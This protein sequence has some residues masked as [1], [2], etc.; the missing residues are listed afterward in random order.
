MRFFKAWKPVATALLFT[1]SAQVAIAHEG[2][3]HGARTTKEAFPPCHAPRRHP[4]RLNLSQSPKAENSRSTLIGLQHNE[5]VL[6]RSVAVETPQGS[7]EAK[8]APDGTYRLPA[9]WS[10][11]PGHYDLIFTVAK[12]NI[13]DVV[14]LTLDIPLATTGAATS[15]AGGFA[16]P[17]MARGLKENLSEN[18]V[19]ILIAL[20]VTFLAGGL[21]GAIWARQRNIA[22]LLLVGAG[23]IC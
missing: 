3:D 19:A 17:A 5:P 6:A 16:T 23:L 15:P 8:A 9:P 12:D 7:V 22:R 2:E 11:A 10:S 1:L 18:H 21:G 14:T 4:I 20:L 13:A